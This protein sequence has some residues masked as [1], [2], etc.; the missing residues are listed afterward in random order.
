MLLDYINRFG[1]LSCCY[2]D[3]RLYFSLVTDKAK[4][5]ACR[6]S[7]IIIISHQLVSNMQGALDASSADNEVCEQLHVTNNLDWQ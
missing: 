2:G 7:F 5:R 6:A 1:D 4:V 3:M